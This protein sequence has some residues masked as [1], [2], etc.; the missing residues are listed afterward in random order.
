MTDPRLLGTFRA[1]LIGQPS[2]GKT[3]LAVRL[4]TE[5]GALTD[6]KFDVI[7]LCYAVWQ[8][9]YAKF[10]ESCE[11]FICTKKLP[12]KEA[13]L[14]DLPF[15]KQSGNKLLICDDQ[16][17]SRADR[18]M[19]VLSKFYVNYSRHWNVSILLLTHHLLSHYK[20]ASVILQNSTTILLFNIG[21]QLSIINLL[22]KNLENGPKFLAEVYRQAVAGRKYRYLVIDLSQQLKDERMKYRSTIDRNDSVEVYQHGLQ[23]RGN[24]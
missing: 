22:A 6:L 2:S 13:E 21:R 10:A 20:E 1:I 17:S 5:S 8:D 14:M 12:Q 3:S 19:S 9:I 11:T 23:V 18:F 24:E 16:V 7:Y 4:A 15:W